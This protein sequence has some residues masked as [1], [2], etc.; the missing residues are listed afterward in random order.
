VN[1]LHGHAIGDAALKGLAR[2]LGYAVRT[3]DRVLR[4]GGEEF[5]VV[6]RGASIASACETAERIRARVGE[7]VRAGGEPLR[8]SIGVAHRDSDERREAL[9]ARADAALYEAKRRG[10]DRVVVA[11]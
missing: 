7:A 2:E 5:L 9:L 3:D 4:L 6:L 1:D 11:D 8:I 10:R